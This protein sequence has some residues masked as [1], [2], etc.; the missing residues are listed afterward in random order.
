MALIEEV[1]GTLAPS[2]PP[3]PTKKR[4]PEPLVKTTPPK[5][6]I[7]ETTAQPVIENFQPKKTKHQNL[8]LFLA[9]MITGICSIYAVDMFAESIRKN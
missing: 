1:W 2:S 8:M 6:D 7:G 4:E 5:P 9:L 3:P